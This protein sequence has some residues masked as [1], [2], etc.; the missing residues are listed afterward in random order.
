MGPSRRVA[1]AMLACPG[2]RPNV[3]WQWVE[4]IGGW[5][6]WQHDQLAHRPSTSLVPYAQANLTKIPNELSDEQVV[7]LADLRQP[8]QRSGVRGSAHR[9]Q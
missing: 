5:R 6:F 3:T 7:L 9:M 2:I 8:L 1:N 4:A